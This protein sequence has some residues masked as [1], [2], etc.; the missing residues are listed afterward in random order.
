MHR[1]RYFY[2]YSGT[3]HR[4]EAIANSVGPQY[5]I[6]AA[7]MTFEV[8]RL[9]VPGLQR[10]G[11]LQ[12]LGRLGPGDVLSCRGLSALGC[13]AADVLL[14]LETLWARK[15]ETHCRTLNPIILEVHYR[16]AFAMLRALAKLDQDMRSD[17]ATGSLEQAR[18]GGV[19]LGRPA[20]AA[21]RDPAAVTEALR[22]VDLGE[23][24]TAVAARFGVHRRSIQ[25]LIA[26]RLEVGR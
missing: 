13:S 20:A 19:K 1:T 8:G 17:R 12:L 6:H 7:N 16:T 24:L 5:L 9:H 26:A 14:T 3:Q 10:P 15:I 21:L 11:F 25:R 22:L 2:D 18:L 23:T 4:S